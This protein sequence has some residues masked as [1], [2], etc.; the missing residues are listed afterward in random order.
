[1]VPIVRLINHEQCDRITTSD[2][3]PWIGPYKTVRG[4][5]RGMTRV[6]H[7]G[8]TH[9]GYRQYHSSGRQADFLAAFESVVDDAIELAVDAV[10]HAGDLFHDTRPSLHDVMETIRI[11]RTLRAAEIPFLAI[12]GNHEGTRDRQWLDLF[13]DLGLAVHL[14]AA[15]T[16][17]GE[18]TVYG[19]DYLP[20][21]RRDRLEFELEPPETPHTALVAHGL[22]EPF[23]HAEW[24]TEAFLDRLSVDV[25]AL[26]LGDNHSPGRAEVG[27]TWV[28]Y[29]GSTERA[30]AAER[31]A[32]G[33]NLVTFDGEVRIGRRTIAD[34]RRFVYV[35]CELRGTQGLEAI[36]EELAAHELADAVVIVSIAGEGEPV[37]PAAIEQTALDRGALAVRVT[38]ERE[39]PEEDRPHAE[40][41]DPDRAIEAR[42]RSLGLSEAGHLVDAVVRDPDVADANVRSRV[43]SRVETLLAEQ[44]SAFEPGDPIAE[45]GTEDPSDEPAEESRDQPEPTEADRPTTGHQRSIGEFR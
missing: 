30:S 15:G 8:D 16:R 6:I 43:R 40:F 23:A 9:I 38:D 1:M 27:D 13:A 24:D 4:K 5:Q 42:V 32:R 29:C 21:A 17:I 37:Q 34:T 18:V 2:R 19:L 3:R 7:T 12:V 45:Q 22:F 31:E 11:L 26:L 33:Y 25:D 39:L 41:A 28:T 20:P 35:D 14:D 36:R 44:S 10:V